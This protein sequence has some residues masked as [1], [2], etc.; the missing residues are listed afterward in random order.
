LAFAVLA[1]VLIVVVALVA[2]KVGQQVAVAE[3]S[4]SEI[5]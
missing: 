3:R 2:F 5:R 4:L 1:V